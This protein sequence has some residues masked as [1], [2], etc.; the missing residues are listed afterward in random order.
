VR[1]WFFGA[2]SAMLFVGT[3]WAQTLEVPPKTG[4]VIFDA[5]ANRGNARAAL[6]LYET[7]TTI[8]ARPF[9][10]TAGVKAAFARPTVATTTTVGTTDPSVATNSTRQQ[11]DMVEF[12]LH[13]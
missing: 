9:D 4:R 6:R 11:C 12:A 10:M 3:G 2:A 7:P 1:N 13:R 8:L 5:Y